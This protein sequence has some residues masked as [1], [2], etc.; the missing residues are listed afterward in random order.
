MKTTPKS[1]LAAALFTVSAFIF[2]TKLLMPTTTRII[3]PGEDPIIVGEIFRYTQFDVAVM[4]VSTIILAS[5]TFYLLFANSTI[6]NLPNINEQVDSAKM[7]AQLVLHLLDSDKRKIFQLIIEANGEILQSDLHASTGFPRTKIT[8]ILDY[9][10]TKGLI[11]RKS[12]GMTN[13]I[14]L[15]KNKPE[16]NKNKDS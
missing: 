5:T 3:I 2:A 10:Q 7:D 4:S 11:T 12:C 9:L 15:N 8:R 1:L 13:K 16:Y 6:K 14:V